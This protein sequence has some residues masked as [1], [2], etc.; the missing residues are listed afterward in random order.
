MDDESLPQLTRMVD[1]KLPLYWLIT[2]LIAGLWTLIS[3]WFSVSQL[4][5]NVADLQTTIANS[6]SSI[7]V[8][9]QEVNMMKYRQSQMEAELARLTQRDSK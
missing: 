7:T 3:M 4:V 9:L 6:N 8:V 1:F 5:K 2:G